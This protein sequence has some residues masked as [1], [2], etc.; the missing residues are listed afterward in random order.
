MLRTWKCQLAVLVTQKLMNGC[1]GLSALKLDLDISMDVLFQG[2][3]MGN[4][5]VKCGV[6]AFWQYS[7]GN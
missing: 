5:G 4:H 6:H 3:P 2:V 7:A 1:C